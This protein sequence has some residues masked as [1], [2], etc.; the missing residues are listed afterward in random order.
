M[1]SKFSNFYVEIRVERLLCIFHYLINIFSIKKRKCAFV[2]KVHKICCL[3][4]GI[5]TI[6][7]HNNESQYP[8]LRILEHMFFKG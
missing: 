7:Y 1:V 6:R 8:W 3:H 5:K 4:D 2:S